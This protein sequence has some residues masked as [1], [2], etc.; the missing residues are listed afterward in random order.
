MGDS[1]ESFE[2]GLKVGDWVF[3]R[4]KNWPR[5]V[6]SISL[7]E[8]ESRNVTGEGLYMGRGKIVGA[9]ETGWTVQEENS[10]SLVKVEPGEQIRLMDQPSTEPMTM[11]DLRRFVDEHEDVPDNTPILVSLP[12]GFTCDEDYPHAL[13]E[14]HPEAHTPDT[15][16]LVA[17][18]HLFF[19]SLEDMADLAGQFED[20]G[21]GM[22]AGPQIEMIL[23][24]L[25]A[26]AA[27]RDCDKD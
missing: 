9:D 3:F 24:P 16:Q 10:T 13:P 17:A 8:G 7:G 21:E 5:G 23:L 26:H 6:I 2:S 1:N 11:G 12:V 15:F 20:A 25:E 22:H 18:S 14:D 4:T 19:T 27:L